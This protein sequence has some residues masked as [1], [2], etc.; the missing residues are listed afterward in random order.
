MKYD[1]NYRKALKNGKEVHDAAFIGINFKTVMKD[2]GM[3]LTSEKPYYPSVMTQ[4]QEHFKAYLTEVMNAATG[5]ILRTPD[6]LLGDLQVRM[7]YFLRR[8][9]QKLCRGN[10]RNLSFKKLLSSMVIGSIKSTFCSM[11]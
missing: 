7:H 9:K 6:W 3:T 1:H 5:N 4:E 8:K 11:T 2:D 10:V